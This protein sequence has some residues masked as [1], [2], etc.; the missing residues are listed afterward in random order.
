MAAL[1]IA[2]GLLLL[3]ELRFPYYFLQ[4]DGCNYFLPSF[5]HNWREVLQGYFPAY[6]FHTFAGVPHEAVSQPGVFYI[7]QYLAMG[8]SEGIWR[9]PFAALDVLAWMHILIAVAGTYVLLRYLKVSNIAAVFGALT[10]MSGF[11]LWAGRMWPFVLM[12]GAWFPWMIW[13][14]LRYL[15][16]PSFKRG[17]AMLAFRL[18][19]LYGG[20]PQFFVLAIIFEHSFVLCY[21]LM[22]PP[23]RGR[24]VFIS[25]LLYIFPTALLGMPML[26]PVWAQAANSLERARP[27]YYWVFS[28]LK[29]TPYQWFVGQFC[30]FIPWPAKSDYIS[31]SLPYLSY[32]GFLPALL[33][34]GAARLWRKN[35]SL[36][37]Y[38]L[39]SGICFALAFLWC[40]NL[41]G[42]LIYYVPVL[43]RFRWPFKVVYFAGFF[44]CLIAAIVLNQFQRRWQMAALAVGVANWIAV[45]GF[46]P[47]HAWRIRKYPIPIVSPWQSSLRHGRYV[48]IAKDSFI[49]N[50]RQYEAFNFSELWGQ[51]NLLGYEP[52][53][54]FQQSVEEA[55][56]HIYDGGIHAPVTVSMLRHFQKWSV[57]YILLSPRRNQYISRLRT[58]GYR[59]IKARQGWTLWQ[60]ANAWPRVR[61]RKNQAVTAP[62]IQWAEDGNSILIHLRQWPAH[63]LTL[64]FA[65]NRG[66]R[67]CI[68]ARCRPIPY[69]QN[70]MMH[71]AIPA[72]TPVVRVVYRT[73]FLRISWM[74]ALGTLLIYLGLLWREDRKHGLR[75]KLLTAPVETASPSA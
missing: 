4:D 70:G 55:S 28:A 74:I 68:A 60:N 15:D 38:L 12:L 44:E 37:P 21:A 25:Y 30:P 54:G 31:A 3:L 61:W 62:G 22:K 7:P 42:P 11:T 51:D 69:A 10:A 56:M 45:F 50:N 57:K 43:N 6:N 34:L 9:N 1:G 16:Q 66:F 35:H 24:K 53:L 67:S 26:L 47:N 18:A 23:A 29:L 2:S 13:S 33:P 71:I 49:H 41:I 48:M 46:M 36:R 52:M 32:I 8:L 27:L 58:A 39:A 17:S 5:F 65:N 20:Y 75:Q 63:E 72:G 64:A 19:L 73:P 14:V 40:T 59:K